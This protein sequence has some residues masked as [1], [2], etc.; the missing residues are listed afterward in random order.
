MA[1]CQFSA[2]P[3]LAEKHCLPRQRLHPA[4]LPTAAAHQD[5]EIEVQD[6]GKQECL[7][8]SD[9]IRSLGIHGVFCMPSVGVIPGPSLIHEHKA[10][11]QLA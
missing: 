8:F 1:R 5:P 6:S 9:F 10:D 11:V 3:D 7:A 4:E 2:Y